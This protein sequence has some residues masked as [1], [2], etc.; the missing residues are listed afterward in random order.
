[1]REARILL[2][3]SDE[4][5][6][7]ETLGDQL[8]DELNVKTWA[9][10]DE[11]T[12]GLRYR[13][14]GDPT[15]LGPK[16]GDLLPKILTSLEKLDSKK[17][18]ALRRAE[19]VKVRAGRGW[20]SMLP[21]EVKIEAVAPEGWVLAEL[22]GYAVLLST[23]LDEAL[24]R[25]GLAREVVRRIQDLRKKAGLRIEEKITTYYE[26]DPSLA[27]AIEEHAEYVRRETLSVALVN[28]GAPQGSPTEH[29]RFDGHH[30][31]IGLQRKA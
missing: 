6:V 22:G 3:D 20:V 24:L 9:V 31:V 15:I 29:A 11:A 27:A 23:E 10:F 16:H 2:R 26:A 28:S 7:L 13:V 1:L 18:D 5:R 14:V 12:A 4:R 30:L 17:M 8:V 21:S 25:E 19:P